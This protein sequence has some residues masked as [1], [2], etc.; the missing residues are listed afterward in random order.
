[1]E[2]YDSV[3]N[4]TILGL[5]KTGVKANIPYYTFLSQSELQEYNQGRINHIEEYPSVSDFVVP[6]SKK[7]T[8]ISSIVGNAQ[9]F[10]NTPCCPD[11][12]KSKLLSNTE[13]FAKR[14]GLDLYVRVSTQT[15]LYPK[16]PYKFSSNDE[17]LL[18]KNYAQTYC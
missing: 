2:N 1:V 16:S 14:N 10:S 8:S 18:Y 9:I 6:Y 12:D 7:P 15:G 5:N 17:Y 13:R 3:V 4:S 11:E